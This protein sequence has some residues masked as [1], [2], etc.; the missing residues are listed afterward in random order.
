MSQKSS[1]ARIHQVLRYIWTI[2]RLF[3]ARVGLAMVE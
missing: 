2:V 1:S 3:G